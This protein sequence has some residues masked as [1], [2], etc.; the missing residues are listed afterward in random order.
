LAKY[1]EAEI[2]DTLRRVL[3]VET[4]FFKALLRRSPK[5]QLKKLKTMLEEAYVGDMETMEEL[6]GCLDKFLHMKIQ[7]VTLWRV[8][9][10]Q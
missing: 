10:Y 7:K 9:P 6:S 5:E 1:N 2:S 3:K 4:V 8:S